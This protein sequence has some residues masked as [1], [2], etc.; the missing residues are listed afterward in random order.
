MLLVVSTQGMFQPSAEAAASGAQ[1][2]ELWDATWE[3][4]GPVMPELR[5]ELFPAVIDTPLETV[6]AVEVGVAEETAK[7]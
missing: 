1:H 7:T 4:L 6:P 3:V 2:N 5:E